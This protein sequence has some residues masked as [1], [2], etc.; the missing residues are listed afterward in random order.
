MVV[1]FNPSAEFEPSLP[2]YTCAMNGTIKMNFIQRI[3]VQHANPS[4][5]VIDS[6]GVIISL[7]FFW[8]QDFW[9]AMLFLF[10][11]S[12]IGTLLVWGKNEDGLAR[13]RLGKWM[14]GQ[15][16]PMN[17]LVRGIGT[18]VVAYGFWLHSLIY[19]LIGAALIIAA[20]HWV[21]KLPAQ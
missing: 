8:Y 1:N 11:L 7:Y 4:K 9:W 15:A 5:L 6:I 13:T 16:H 10:G 2:C 3:M 18:I 14:I 12:T 21:L 19:I 17:L 20:R